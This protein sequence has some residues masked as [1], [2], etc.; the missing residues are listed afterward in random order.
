M[1]RIGSGKAL[2]DWVV[3]GRKAQELQRLSKERRL[4]SQSKP[5]DKRWKP[6]MAY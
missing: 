3:K 5:A 4:K 1:R 2:A 6:K